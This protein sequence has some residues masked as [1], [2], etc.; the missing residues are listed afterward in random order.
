MKIIDCFPYFNEKEI[1]ELRL[2]M[3]K[4]HVDR[5]IITEANQTHS[6][7]P[8]EFTCFETLR[9]LGLL[10]ELEHKIT[11]Y[12]YS[13]HDLS[14]EE[15]AHWIRERIQRD[16]AIN[17]FEDDNVYIVSDC[18]EI[19]DPKL[20]SI[21]AEMVSSNKD[22]LFKIPMVN[23]NG[24]ADLVLCNNDGSYTD[25]SPAYMC[26]KHHIEKYSLSELRDS[27]AW[28]KEI[29]FELAF[30]MQPNGQ[31]SISGWHFSW[32]GDKEKLKTKMKSF[33]HYKEKPNQGFLFDN[34]IAAANSPEMEQYLDNYTP[35][36]NTSD[37]YGRNS[38]F[39]KKF[40]AHFLPKEVFD[41]ERVRQ[42]LFREDL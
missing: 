27:N 9:E 14:H 18:D 15:Q 22:K 41:L 6:G 25:W 21:Y 19:I 5:F 26:M 13:Y 33:V 3:L 36:E 7:L 10:E 16:I 31:K 17:F 32:M 11:V 39:L 1:L 20:I 28:G 38:V 29:D 12:Q 37:P 34:I 42:F 30:P 4:D 24:R 2:N 23:L 35:E 40:P 8:K